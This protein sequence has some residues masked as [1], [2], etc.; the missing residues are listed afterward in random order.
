MAVI[1]AGDIGATK[2][3]L[4]LFSTEAGPRAP[5]AQAEYVSRS[6]SSL[7][8]VVQEF[9]KQTA[10][11]VEHAYFGVAGPVVDGTAKTTNLPWLIQ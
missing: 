10:N 6:Y 11:T 7:V 1:L 9:F 3:D 4:A 5:I 2:T 8:A